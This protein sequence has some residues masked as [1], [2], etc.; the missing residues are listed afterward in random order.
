[1]TKAERDRMNEDAAR[2]RMDDSVFMPPE[3]EEMVSYRLPRA[4]NGEKGPLFVSINGRTF[5]IRRGALVRLPRYVA[6]FLDAHA[7]EEE[8][9]AR[10]MDEMEEEFDREAQV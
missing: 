8:A 9:I 1:M 10:R 5:N 7:E 4:A 6:D 2:P 3:D